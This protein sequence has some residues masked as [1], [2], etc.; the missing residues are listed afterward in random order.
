VRT[1]PD[2]SVSVE[3]LSVDAAG[4]ATATFA[5]GEQGVLVVVG[6]TPHTSERAAYEV[7]VE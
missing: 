3:P 2:G 5:P 6:S 7:A 1:A 4:L